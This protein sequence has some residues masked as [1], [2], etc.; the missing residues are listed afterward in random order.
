MK[1]SAALRSLSDSAW[2]L[3]HFECGARQHGKQT[4]REMSSGKSH[5]VK[6]HCVRRQAINAAHWG[7]LAINERI[8]S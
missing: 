7:F 8:E 6:V 1:P 3:Y 5:T 2:W 4:R